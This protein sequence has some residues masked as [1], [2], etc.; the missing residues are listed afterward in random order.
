MEI[1]STSID[2][3]LL[4]ASVSHTRT[5]PRRN[6]FSYGVYYLCMALDEL[7]KLNAV[8]L[9]SYNRG[10]L[11]SLHDK[12]HGKADGSSF[13]RWIRG[14]LNEWK[15]REA[16]GRIMLLTMPRLFGYGFNPVSFWFC[17]DKQGNVRAVVAEVC[18]TFKDRHS[19]ICFHDDHR[20]I[21]KD[22]WIETPKIF[23]VSPFIEIKGKYRFRFAYGEKNIGVWIDYYDENGML[24]TTS[25]TGKRQPLTSLTLLSCFFR[26]PLVTLKVIGLIHYQALKLSLKGIRYHRRQPMPPTE[27]SR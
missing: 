14:L 23:H 8:R 3:G 16:D 12:D 26:C 1:S 21:T 9:L 18:N 25:L 17:L 24:L 13:E 6:A 11:F 27:V 7:P 5:T 19:Y 2:N 22:D 10:N 15:L 4:V 20:P